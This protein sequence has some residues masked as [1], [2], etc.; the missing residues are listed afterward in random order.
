MNNI[1]QTREII[2]ET[3]LEDLTVIPR[4]P[5]KFP[6]K[7]EI[8]KEPWSLKNSVFATYRND[9]DQILE[10]CFETDWA[11]SNIQKVIKDENEI[12]LI[13]NYLRKNYQ[14]IREC[15]KYFAAISSNNQVFSIG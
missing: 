5:P 10:S 1:A 15:Y 14:P 3:Y 2:T 6:R 7:R 13:K 9:T 11:A 12:F 8:E 4:P